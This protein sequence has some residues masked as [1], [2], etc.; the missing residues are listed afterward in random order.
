MKV[1][2][3]K[4]IANNLEECRNPNVCNNPPSPH[5]QKWFTKLFFRF[6]RIQRKW[7]CNIS[8]SLTVVIVSLFEVHAFSKHFFPHT[9]KSHFFTYD[10]EMH[11]KIILKRCHLDN[12]PL[13]QMQRSGSISQIISLKLK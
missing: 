10:F 9:S 12:N 7:N 4:S 3:G 13:L 2:N 8:V 1:F 5:R 11:L 6:F